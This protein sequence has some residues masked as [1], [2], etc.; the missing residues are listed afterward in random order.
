MKMNKQQM[1]IVQNDGN[2]H[3]DRYKE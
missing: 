1:Q 3:S 2:T